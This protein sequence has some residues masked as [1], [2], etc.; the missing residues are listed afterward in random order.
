MIAD[1]V[2]QDVAVAISSLLLIPSPT[3]WGEGEGEGD[4]SAIPGEVTGRSLEHS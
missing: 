3:K 4:K 1:A 2:L